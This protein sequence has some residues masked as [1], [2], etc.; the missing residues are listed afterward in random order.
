[1]F[2]VESVDCSGRHGSGQLIDLLPDHLS[3]LVLECSRTARDEKAVNVV[4]YGILLFVDLDDDAVLLPAVATA[5]DAIA[6]HVGRLNRRV[7]D[8]LTVGCHQ[9][10]SLVVLT[11][12]DGMLIL[13]EGRNR[14]GIW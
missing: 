14:S 4:E 9:M 2:L 10:G 3:V 8:E 5:L 7:R 11:V 13:Q 12:F 6:S 1:M